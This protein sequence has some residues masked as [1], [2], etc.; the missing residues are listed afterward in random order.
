MF[1]T[2]GSEDQTPPIIVQADAAKQLRVAGR[3]H[4]CFGPYSGVADTYSNGVPPLQRE[5]YHF[6]RPS[7]YTLLRYAPRR[8]KGE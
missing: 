4:H 1:V 3:K 8:R 6:E 7:R 5:A 2:V